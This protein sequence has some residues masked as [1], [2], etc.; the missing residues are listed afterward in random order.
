MSWSKQ[1]R[2]YLSGNQTPFSCEH[3]SNGTVAWSQHLED[4]FF[5]RVREKAA[6][7]AREILAQ[8]QDEAEAIKD[9]AYREGLARGRQEAGRE[10]ERMRQELSERFEAFLSGLDQD[11]TSLME[12]YKQDIVSFI[13]LAVNKV[14]QQELDENRCEV[15]RNLLNEALELVDREREVTLSVNPEDGDLVRELMEQA[16]AGYP[17][18]EHWQIKTTPKVQPGGVVLETAGS[19]IDNTIENRWQAVN[20][21]LDQLAINGDK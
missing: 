15:L 18:L 10:A 1:G 2:I 16:R 7:R 8:A 3:L 13:S 9:R 14:V 4:E 17:R 6:L 20:E 19:R 11:K 5:E 21:V 12:R